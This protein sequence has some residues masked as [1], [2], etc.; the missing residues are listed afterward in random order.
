VRYWLDSDAARRGDLHVVRYE[1]LRRDPVAS[2]GGVV[3][4]LGIHRSEGDIARAVEHNE[5][6]QMRAKEQRA[7]AL[8]VKSHASAEPFVG[9]GGLGSWRSKLSSENVASIDRFAHDELVRLGYGT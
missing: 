9:R 7:P 8:E 2:V 5:L 6:T 4:H 3:E 1:D